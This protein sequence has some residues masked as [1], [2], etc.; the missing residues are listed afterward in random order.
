MS[1]A[2]VHIVRLAM[3][4]LLAAAL[5]ACSA[6]KPSTA[7]P[8]PSPIATATPTRTPTPSATSTPTPA[9]A[10]TASTTAPPSS[11]GAPGGAYPEAI[12]TAFVSACAGSQMT[13]AAGC[14]CIYRHMEGNV[15]LSDYL[16]EQRQV[17]ANGRASEAGIK[18]ITDAATA[19]K[20]S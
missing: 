7:T 14:E 20:I 5:L 3:I 9:V 17:Q 15:P 13:T 16:A 8:T 6:P 12:R 2:R 19:C 11:T 18:W 10:S 4:A 1:Q